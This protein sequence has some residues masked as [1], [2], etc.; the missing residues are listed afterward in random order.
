MYFKDR[1]TDPVFAAQYIDNQKK[2]SAHRMK[3]VA[4]KKRREGKCSRYPSGMVELL[5]HEL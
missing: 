5:I 4:E 3:E 1:E 2:A